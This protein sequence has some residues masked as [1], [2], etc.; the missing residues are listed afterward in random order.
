[1]K[2]AF[3]T[4]KLIILIIVALVIPTI[5]FFS[6]SV[7]CT[8]NTNVVLPILPATGIDYDYSGQGPFIDV[9]CTVV[10]LIEFL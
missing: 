7:R 1:M 9:P 2:F 10:S 6:G 3:D 4:K 8:Y 5:F